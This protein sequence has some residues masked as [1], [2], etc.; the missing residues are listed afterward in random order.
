MDMR[1]LPVTTALSHNRLP[2]PVIRLAIGNV[3]GAPGGWV[4]SLALSFREC[5]HE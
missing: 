4:G 2:G 3:F 5:R 1:A